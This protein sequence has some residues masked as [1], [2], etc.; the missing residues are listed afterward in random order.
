MSSCRKRMAPQTTETANQKEKAMAT[1]RKPIPASGNTPGAQSRPPQKTNKHQDSLREGKWGK[2][3]TWALN[4]AALAA[5]I[6]F[7][8]WAPLSYNVTLDG[9]RSNDASTSS[10]INAV[11]AVSSQAS[12]AATT[13]SAMLDNLSG[14]LG[15][16]GQLWLVDFCASQT[17][18]G[19]KKGGG[20]EKCSNK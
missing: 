6:V 14:Q 7:G 20:T 4:V 9:N 17:V 10:M 18:S 13:Q 12:V 19:P 3:F 5:A 15:A 11:L 8:I 1:T 16:I 2:F